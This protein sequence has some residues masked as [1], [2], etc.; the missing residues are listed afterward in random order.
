MDHMFRG[1]TDIGGG[2]SG[3]SGVGNVG[4]MQT[5]YQRNYNLI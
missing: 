5:S 3:T 4:T 1:H 2:L